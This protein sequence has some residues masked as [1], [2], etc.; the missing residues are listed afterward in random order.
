MMHYV[1]AH[2]NETHGVF[3]VG[4][5]SGKRL[6]V[7]GNRSK[8]W[9]RFAKDGFSAFVISNHDTADEAMFFE[10]DAIANFKR[11]GLCHANVALGGKGVNV[12]HRWWGDKISASLK[13][14]KRPSGKNSKSF[15]SFCDDDVLTQ[16][17]KDN[18]AQQIGKMFNVSTQTVINHLNL[19]GVK[20]RG[21]DYSSCKVFCTT[22]G[23]TFPSITQAALQLGVYRENI[24]KVLAGKYSHTGGFHF[25]K[26]DQD[27]DG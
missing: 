21:V 5:G 16:L 24:R 2:E 8:L 11:M 3:Y 10:S 19:I 23:E 25:V 20:T 4:K 6:H 15:K 7:T 17:Y 13:G 18:T 27:N 14:K 12:P 22:T 1:Y 9:R 26:K